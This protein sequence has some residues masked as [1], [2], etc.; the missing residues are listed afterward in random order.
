MSIKKLD[1]QTC[2][3]I[4]AGEIVENPSSIVKELL[5]NALD[6]GAKRLRIS[7]KKGGLEEITVQ[8]DGCGIPSA[9]LRLSL[10]RHATSKIVALE[11]LQK[12]DTLGFRGEALPSIAS[13]SKLSIATRCEEE[14]SGSYILLEGGKEKKFKE[15]GLPRGTKVTVRDIFYNAPAR[16]KFLKGA[17]AETAR[18]TKIVNMLALSRPEVSFTLEREGKV[19]LETPGDGNLLNALIKIYGHDLARQLRPLNFGREGFLISGYVSNPHFS[20]HSKKYQH[21]FVNKRYVQS[22]L[23]QEI[24]NKRF[25][26]LVTSQRFPVAFLSLF[27][28]PH[29]LDINVHPTKL[30]IRFYE[31]KVV[32]D[33]LEEALDEVFFPQQDQNHQSDFE[34]RVAQKTKDIDEKPTKHSLTSRPVAPPVPFSE[35]QFL[36]EKSFIVKDKTQN[37]PQVLDNTETGA[38]AILVSPTIILAQLFNTYIL[39]QQEDELI[40]VDQHAAHERII[41]EKLIQEEEQLSY[42]EVLP[43]PFKLPLAQAEDLS[44]KMELLAET[45]L[46]IEQFGNNTFIIRAVPLC[47]QNFF[48]PEMILDILEDETFLQ[49]SGANFKKEAVLRLSCK[50]AIKANHRLTTKEIEALLEQLGRCENPFFCPH[51]RPVIFKMKKYELE[52][53]FKR[54]G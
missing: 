13:V 20:I 47:L 4:A 21:F 5:E 23:L 48:S 6:A 27:L 8:D 16:L 35:N 29:N 40:F 32:N 51:G 52:K 9:E 22:R 37:Y 19:Y 26:C 25:S 30:Q 46:K 54:R 24:L 53:Q 38:G 2:N 33:F 17:P 42:Q 49:L 50:T 28:L 14:E 7:I 36:N 43:F 10:E 12:I 44:N 11:D 15:V 3:Q 45:G 1:L 34:T 31:E 39:L 18:I 41:W